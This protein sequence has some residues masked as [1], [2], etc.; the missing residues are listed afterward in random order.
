MDH[1][2]PGDLQSSLR[3]GGPSNSAVVS[4]VY[5]EFPLRTDSRPEDPGSDGLEKLATPFVIGDDA[6]VV[7]DSDLVDGGDF[8]SLRPLLE[9]D[10]VLHVN[11]QAE[12]LREPF[13]GRPLFAGPLDRGAQAKNQLGSSVPRECAIALDDLSFLLPGLLEEVRLPADLLHGPFGFIKHVHRPFPLP[14][15][16]F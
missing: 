5:L 4:W 16:L 7:L 1:P 2:G 9:V 8:P 15:R 6:D 14:I 13:Q 11:T 10:G 12:L 3:F